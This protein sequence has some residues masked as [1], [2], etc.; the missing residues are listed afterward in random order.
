MPFYDFKCPSGCGYF[1]DIYVPLSEH[2]TTTCSECGDVLETVI[3]EVALIGPMPS[4]PLVM[5]QL[6]RTFESG[7]EWRQYQR[8]NPDCA[9][10][11]ADSSA[12]REHKEAVRDKAEARA[13][14]EGYRDFD[15]KKQRRKEEKIKRSGK[16]DKKIFIH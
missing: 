11:S 2:G 5:K 4:K 16:L 1:G 14:R 12:W 9:M 3:S 8:E 13:R 15:D 10:V 7:S 6:G